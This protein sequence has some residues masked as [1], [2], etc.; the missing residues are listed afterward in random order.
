MEEE[1]W[2]KLW[3]C[4]CCTSQSVVVCLY[5]GKD[6]GP[7]P[8]TA[9]LDTPHGY[10]GAGGGGRGGPAGHYGAHNGK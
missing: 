1:R 9:L 6:G 5:L 7:P 2:E 10:N 8:K 3:D 4:F